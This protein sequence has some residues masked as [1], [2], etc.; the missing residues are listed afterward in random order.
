[1]GREWGKLSKINCIYDVGQRNELWKLKPI[2]AFISKT[3]LVGM[4]EAVSVVLLS[5]LVR[6]CFEMT[7]P[8]TS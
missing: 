5:L 7:V 1:M 8:D 2:C 6:L 4:L 3:S